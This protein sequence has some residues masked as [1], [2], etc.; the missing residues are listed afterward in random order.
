M[1]LQLPYEATTAGSHTIH[2]RI[3]SF[4]DNENEVLGEVIEKSAFLV[5][6]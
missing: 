5:P 1:R 3:T 2:F 4:V 6:R